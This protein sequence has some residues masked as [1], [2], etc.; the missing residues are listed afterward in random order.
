MSDAEVKSEMQT[1][2]FDARFPNTNQTKHCWQN[3][4]DYFKCIDARGEDFAPC[5]QF[6]RNYHSLCPNSWVEKWDTQREAGENPSNF[7]L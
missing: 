4:V 5:K 3:Y 2:P 6:W 7:T 1:A